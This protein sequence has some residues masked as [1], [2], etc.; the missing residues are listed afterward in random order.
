MSY[1]ADPIED[2]YLISGYTREQMCR[3]N[4]P[5]KF[6]DRDDMER[7]KALAPQG[8][9]EKADKI[10]QAINR[11][12]AYFGDIV[13]LQ[14]GRDFPLGYCRNHHELR[15]ILEYLDRRDFVSLNVSDSDGTPVTLGADGLAEIER[16]QAAN[17][18]SA[19]A[20]VAMWF[21]DDLKPAYDEAIA[22]GIEDAGYR[23]VRI[24]NEEFNE[25]VVARI[26]AE[27]RE[28]RFVVADFTGQRNGV[29]F[30]AGFALGLS[31]PV[32]WLCREDEMRQAHFD[33]NHFNH[34]TWKPEEL[35]GLRERLANR[36]KAT[37]G[38]GPLKR[39]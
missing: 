33:T 38:A 3:G 39:A 23:S 22:P 4:G 37:I 29:Y 35:D 25:D 14:P 26:L 21:A 34:I 15:A 12:S 17:I 18:E 31:L 9:A 30:E 6:L 16:H 2:A 20:F 7:A 5:P 10:L 27:V 24:D 8:I 11:R 28:S 19:K 1:R 36:I 32:I 13:Y